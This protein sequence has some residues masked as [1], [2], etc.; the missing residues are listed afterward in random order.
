MAKRV[1]HVFLTE[2]ELKAVKTLQKLAE[3]WPKTLHLQ[4]HG[5][6]LSVYK[7]KEDG[8]TP[9]VSVHMGDLGYDAQVDVVDPKAL[10]THVHGLFIETTKLVGTEDD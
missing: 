2:S 4:V 8:E 3:T 9:T 7:G 6:A 10:V 5:N 1:T